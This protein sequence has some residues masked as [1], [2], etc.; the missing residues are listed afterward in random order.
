LTSESCQ[1]RTNK[2]IIVS[3]YS[4]SPALEAVDDVL[5]ISDFPV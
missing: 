4:V 2:E 1:R 3:G 5:G